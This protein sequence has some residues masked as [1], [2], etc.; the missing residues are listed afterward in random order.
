MIPL[1]KS[2]FYHETFTKF[3]L[4]LYLWHNKVLS[5]NKQCIEFEKEFSKW[6]GRRDAVFVNSGSSANLAIIQA[7]INLG[8]LKKGD[9]VGF[10]ALTWATNVMPLLQ[11]GLKPVPIDVETDTLNISSKRIP[12]TIKAL[13]ITHLLGLCGDMDAIVNVCKERNIILLEDT[14][15]SLGSVYKKTK[16]GNFGLASTFSFYVGHHMSTVEGGMVATDDPDLADMLRIVRAHGWDRNLPACDQAKVRQ[17]YGINDEFYS[18]YTF[19]AN[20]Y[21]LRPT[22]IAGFIGTTQ[23]PYLDEIIAKREENFFSLY[24]F[25]NPDF[26]PLAVS[27]LDVLSSF[28]IPLICKDQKTR[29]K[30]L[31]KLNGVVE[32]RPVVGG[33]ITT[34]PFYPKTARACPNAAFVHDNGFYIGNN[35]DLTKK[36]IKTIKDLLC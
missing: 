33:N 2:T 13:F 25:T 28:A 36:E 18:R 10:S 7:L 34:Q 29:D 21:N 4:T 3:L 5:F 19:Y 35:P 11:L 6:Q 24:P 23:L 27:H 15:E 30:Y 16:L 26:L 17:K 20:G 9:R 8:R 32:T 14:C 1:I 12:K 22:D 31:K